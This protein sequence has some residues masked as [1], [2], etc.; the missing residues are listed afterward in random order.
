MSYQYLKKKKKKYNPPY[1]PSKSRFTILRQSCDEIQ[2]F[3]PLPTILITEFLD[4]FF[5][6]YNYVY[7]RDVFEF[8]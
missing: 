1:P 8:N 6:F 2:T 3:F 5:P 7:N 4:H